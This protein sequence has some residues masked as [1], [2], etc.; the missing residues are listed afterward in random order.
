[1]SRNAETPRRGVLAVVSPASAFTAVVMY[2]FFDQKGWSATYIAFEAILVVTCVCLVLAL[3]N[4]RVFWWG[5]RVVA[6]IIFASYLG[7]LAYELLTQ[8]F[9]V[10]SSPGAPSPMK[11][12]VGFCLIGIPCLLYA[13]AGRTFGSSAGEVDEAQLSTKDIRY[14]RIATAARWVF[15]AASLLV[16]VARVVRAVVE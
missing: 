10:D 9:S 2:L 4:P 8:P 16:V 7:Y 6:F 12:I 14:R 11:A 5:P 1:M 13:L 3:I 15:L